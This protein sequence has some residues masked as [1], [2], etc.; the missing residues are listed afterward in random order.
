MNNVSYS[1]NK[2]KVL[3]NADVV[4]IGGGTAGV[5]AA[6]SALKEINTEALVNLIKSYLPEG[7]RYYP[8]T[9]V[10]DHPK[11]FSIAETVREKIFLNLSEEIPYS[12]GVYT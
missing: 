3:D 5:V 10:S 12:I 11:T 8:V 4:V 6:I 9:M 1:K 2:I 7:P